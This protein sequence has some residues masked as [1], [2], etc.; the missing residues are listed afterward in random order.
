MNCYRTTRI[1]GLTMVG[2][3][4]LLSLPAGCGSD[5]AGT[6]QPAVDEHAGHVM[7]QLGAETARRMGITL[8]EARRESLARELRAPGEVAWDETRL[9]TVSLRFGGWAERLHADFTGRFVQEGTPLVDVYSPEL[10]SAQEDLLAAVRLAGELRES[11]VPTSVD[12][13]DGVLQAARDRLRRWQ[14]SDRDIAHVE[15]T[16]E[17]LETLTLTAPSTGFVVEKNIQEGERF[18]SGAPLYR[19]ADLSRVWIQ[20]E[21]Y[22]D[23]L[24]FLRLGDAVEVSIGAYPGERFDGRISYRYPEVDSER[25]TARIRIEL[26]NPDG[27]LRPGM[28]GTARTTVEVAREAITVPRD[29][30]M[31][32][33]ERALVFVETD[34][35]EYMAHEVALGAE[36]GDR[37]QILAGIEEGDR[38]VARAGFILDAE[39]RLMESMTG[40]PDMPGMEMDHGG[41]DA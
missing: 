12:R 3:A 17:V 30:V 37:I 10:V 15:E 35:G 36:A 41:P 13:S 6:G 18:D 21:V 14:I 8:V 33:G 39:S 5:R 9:S 26:P 23:D 16:G 38:V 11:R 31:H 29:A 34:Q 20:V 24:R 4:A 25:R 7:P 1:R 32:T 28:F 19:I 27:R 2:L 22:E 40:Q